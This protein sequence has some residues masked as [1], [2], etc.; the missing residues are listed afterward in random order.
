MALEEEEEEEDDTSG[1]E[2]WAGLFSKVASTFKTS[3]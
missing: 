3:D 1:I 2:L